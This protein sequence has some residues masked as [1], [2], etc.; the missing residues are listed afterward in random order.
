M[1][2]HSV[3]MLLLQ[4]FSL[5]IRILKNWSLILVSRCH[6]IFQHGMSKTMVLQH[7]PL[8]SL[9][10][11][12]S[13]A[14]IARRRGFVWTAARRAT[15]RHTFAGMKIVSARLGTRTDRT[16]WPLPGRWDV[17]S[18]D[19][20]TLKRWKN[21]AVGLWKAMPTG[22]TW[23]WKMLWHDAWYLNVYSVYIYIYAQTPCFTAWYF[24]WY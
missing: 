17:G 11:L 18:T 16:R 14:P 1:R 6:S 12:Q 3:N 7:K 19:V 15:A 10:H 24:S 2:L 13:C 8:D 20:E 4:L 5:R 9:R 21:T 23:A 22:L